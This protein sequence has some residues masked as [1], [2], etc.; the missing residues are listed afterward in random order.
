VEQRAA[1]EVGDTQAEQAEVLGGCGSA[2]G[3]A[4]PA[5]AD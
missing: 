5:L 4:S 3:Q 1:Q 2:A